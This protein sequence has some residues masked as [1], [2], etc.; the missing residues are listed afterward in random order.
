MAQQLDGVVRGRSP[1]GLPSTL[2]DTT[3]APMTVLRSGAI[4]IDAA[5]L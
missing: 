2:V 5:A 1:G 3:V 4:Q